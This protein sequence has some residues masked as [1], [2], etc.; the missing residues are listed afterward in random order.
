M[1]VPL[2]WQIKV[3]VG[4]IGLKKCKFE[5]KAKFIIFRQKLNTNSIILSFLFYFVFDK[6]RLT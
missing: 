5:N 6:F 3:S 1:Q 2:E 4:W